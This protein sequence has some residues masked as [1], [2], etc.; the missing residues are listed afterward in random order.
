MK[1]VIKKK[2]KNYTFFTFLIFIFPLHISK[3]SVC[4]LRVFFFLRYNIYKVWV[5]GMLNDD[6]IYAH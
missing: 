3:F 1:Y 2:T 6:S 5:K 4:I